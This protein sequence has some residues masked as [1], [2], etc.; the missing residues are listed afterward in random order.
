M[1]YLQNEEKV[2]LMRKA[3]GK[4]TEILVDT[5]L[6]KGIDNHLLG[7]KEMATVSGQPV[8]KIFAD[9]SYQMSNNFILSTSQVSAILHTL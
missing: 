5:I 6:G 9:E 2:R 3:I 8:P 7:L 4:Q 1:I